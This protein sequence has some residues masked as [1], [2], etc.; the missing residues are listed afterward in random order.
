MIFY[1]YLL[2][3]FVILNSANAQVRL[4]IDVLEESNFAELKGKRIGL[5]TNHASRNSEGLST[6]EVFLSQSEFELKCLY[7]PEHGFYTTVPA[8]E[9]VENEKLFG[10]PVL[11]LYGKNRRPTKEYLDKCDIVV[12]DIQDIGVR[13]YTYI[14]TVYNVIDACSQYK[15]PVIILD[16]P[17]PLSGISVDGN[18]VEG[19]RKSFVA[20]IPVPYIHSMTIGEIAMMINEEKWLGMGRECDLTI[21]KMKNWNRSMSWQETGLDWYPTSPHVPTI[22]AVNGLATIGILGELGIISIGIGTTSPFQYLGSPSFNPEKFTKFIL[23]EFPEAKKYSDGFSLNG[24]RFAQARY[25]PFYGMY[26]GKAC[27]GFYLIKEN[28]NNENFLPYTCGLKIIYSLTQNNPEIF[29]S[30]KEKSIN[31]F[32]K[33]TGTGKIWN[34]IKNKN[35]LMKE[36]RNGVLEFLDKRDKYL[37][38]P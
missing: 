33:V 7:V 36:S 20:K 21:I 29:D 32:W 14:S 10:V 34:N 24:M 4:G 30:V 3:F 26:K 28:E 9:H 15:K 31:M 23:N 8:G 35:K 18:V 17:N 16:R 22:G 2:I 11:S 27:N 25:Q 19:D 37:L 13:S 6:A 5:L 1:K 38:Y 12:I